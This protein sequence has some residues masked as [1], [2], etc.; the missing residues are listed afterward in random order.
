MP[1]KSSKG[2]RKQSSTENNVM[3]TPR[4]PKCNSGPE[5]QEL[6]IDE[7]VYL[8]YFCHACNTTYAKSLKRESGK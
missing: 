2:E 4:C 5:R 3:V 8:I 6:R 1:G 7:H